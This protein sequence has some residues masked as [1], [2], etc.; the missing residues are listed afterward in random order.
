MEL[1]GLAIVV[2]LIVLGMFFAIKYTLQKPPEVKKPFMQ[3]ELATNF[4]NALLSTSTEECKPLSTLKDL[5]SDCA[6][7]SLEPAQPGLEQKCQDGKTA[8]CGKSKEIIN[9][10][11]GNTLNK[12]GK[13]YVLSVADEKKA[14]FS[15]DSPQ[16]CG[17]GEER[18]KAGLF[19][20]PSKYRTVAVRLDI[21]G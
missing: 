20:V 15:I 9:G 10:I 14:H 7:Q 18:G 5:L 4:V 13:R 8:Y 21:C 11:A 6:V 1:M 2:L 16:K 12:W 3:A 17:A 19:Y